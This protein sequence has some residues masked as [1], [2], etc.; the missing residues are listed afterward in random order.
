MF[1]YISIL[2]VM[3]LFLCSTV[4]AAEPTEP[5]VVVTQQ[6]RLDAET[7]VIRDVRSL[8]WG[9]G[10]F[11]CGFFA[12]GASVAYAPTV[13]TANLMGKSPDYIIAYTDTYRSA[14]KRKNI[15]AAGIGCLMNVSIIALWLLVLR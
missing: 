13:P 5:D 6:A 14:M 10:G 7:H 3:S 8:E 12:L 15:T 1:K 11:L 4:S 2:M 9:L